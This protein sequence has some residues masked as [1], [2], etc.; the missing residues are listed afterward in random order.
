MQM[1]G[2][3]L[4]LGWMLIRM[5]IEFIARPWLTAGEALNIIQKEI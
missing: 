3:P 5:K 4:F 1:L 2:L